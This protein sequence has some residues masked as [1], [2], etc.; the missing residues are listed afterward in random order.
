ME[1]L[2]IGIIEV[3]KMRKTGS[4]QCVVNNHEEI[5]IVDMSEVDII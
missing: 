5:T 4:G 1:R 2:S 3:S